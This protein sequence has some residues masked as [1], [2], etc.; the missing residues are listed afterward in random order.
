MKSIAFINQKGGVGKTTSAINLGYFLAK[1]G[2]K[3]LLVDADPQGNLSSVFKL[4]GDN[5]KNNTIYECYM[6]NKKLSDCIFKTDI[7][8][9]DVVP[10]DI[11]LADAD[12][13]L[14]GSGEEGMLVLRKS[15]TDSNLDKYNYIICDC[16]P[17]LGFLTSN[18]MIAC[19]QIIIP[20]EACEFSLDGIDMI[21]HA[22]FK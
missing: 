9:I 22:H 21:S 11:N 2:N 5:I 8:N 20:L 19:K 14:S 1:K 12:Y 16:S 6:N 7:E 18:V 15:F 3:V 10:A 13:F 4:K 17:S